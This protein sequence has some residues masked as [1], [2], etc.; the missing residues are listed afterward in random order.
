MELEQENTIILPPKAG[1]LEPEEREPTKKPVSIRPKRTANKKPKQ[2]AAAPVDEQA[3]QQLHLVMTAA[4]GSLCLLLI[5]DKDYVPET[6]ELDA[7]LPPLENILLRRVHMS[8]ALSPDFNDLIVLL[9]GLAAYGARIRTVRANRKS[10][11]KSAPNSTQG[12][13]VQ[14]S[15]NGKNNPVAAFPG[16]GENWATIDDIKAT[17]SNG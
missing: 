11:T 4:V 12:R 8:G 13:P 3:R 2:A 5:S 7:I 6:Q 9:F 10:S 15:T 16:I 17:S 1:V 14:T